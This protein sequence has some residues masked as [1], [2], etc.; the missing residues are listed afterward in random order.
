[1][2]KLD[3]IRDE[4]NIIDKEIA[5]LFEKRLNLVV[6]VA[7][8]K[9]EANLPIFHKS[10]EE[11]VLNKIAK[12]IENDK[13][14]EPAKKLFV[15]IMK[16]SKGV[17]TSLL[18]PKNI[19]IVGFM[20]SG[21]TSVGTYLST[22]LSMEYVDVDHMIEKEQGTS[23]SN[24]FEAKGEE[25]FRELETQKVKSLEVNRSTVISCGG[26]VVLNNDNVTSL[27]KNGKI[28]LLTASPETI[29]NRLKEDSSRP[30]L[31]SKTKDQIVELLEKR[32]ILYENCADVVINTDNKSIEDICNE[33]IMS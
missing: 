12:E 19:V 22:I 9:K 2:K 28:I 1:M 26:G 17:Q 15:E 27:K 24:I 3:S 11:E 4:I 8:A 14:I 6:Q 20:G 7:K 32:K 21:K 13:F 18:F 30:L 25:Y 5:N 33:I 10:R 29:Y 23:I 16:I 31:K